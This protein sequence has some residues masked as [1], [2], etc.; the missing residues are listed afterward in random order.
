MSLT[1]TRKQ[2]DLLQGFYTHCCSAYHNDSVLD[3]SFWAAQLD[4]H[5]VPLNV[6]NTVSTLAKEP[7]SVCLYLSTHLRKKSI[8]IH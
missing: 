8:Y 5:R 7:D 1:I 3:G 6:Q 4:L 2:Y